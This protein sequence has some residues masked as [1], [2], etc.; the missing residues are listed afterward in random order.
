MKEIY[1]DIPGYEGLYQVSNLGNVK[2]LP[3]G[4]GNGNRERLL[5][6]E[7]CAK[8]H[9]SY[10]RVALSKNGVVTR[11]QVHRLVAQAFVSNPD[12]KTIV[13]HIDNNGLNND[14][15]NLEWCTQVENM[16]HSS[17]QGRQNSPRSLG[18]VAAAKA[19]SKAYDV[20]N[21]LLIGTIIGQLTILSYYRDSTLKKP[22]TPKFVCRC[23]CGNI[24]TKIKGNLFNPTRPKMCNECSFILRKN[25]KDKDIVNTM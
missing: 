1:K 22:T 8:N 6:L 24:T 4:D 13:N 10:Y 18:G 16:Q 5:K 2:S 21:N 23:S 14:S 11:Y 9:T 25:L 7:V 15:S 20:A 19:R 3:K 17:V 12:N